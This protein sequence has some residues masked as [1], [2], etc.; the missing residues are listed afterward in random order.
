MITDNS[1]AASESQGFT[2]CGP[3]KYAPVTA[4][5]CLPQTVNRATRNSTV[6]VQAAAIDQA[7]PTHSSE[8]T[9]ASPQSSEGENGVV[10]S[11]RAPVVP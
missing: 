8:S 3:L 4:Q 5:N 7:L 10:L 1:S 6:S 2:L 11:T 9:R